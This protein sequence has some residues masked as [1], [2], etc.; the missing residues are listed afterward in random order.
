MPKILIL[1]AT[2]DIAEATAYVFAKAGFDLVLS[3]RNID[4][5]VPLKQD[6]EL[7]LKVDV[8]LLEL[9]AEDFDGHHKVLNNSYLHDIEVALLAFGYLGDQNKAQQDFKERMQLITVNYTAAVNCFE[10]IA[11]AFEKR[12]S[13]CIIG[14][15]SVAGERGRQ[16]NYVYGSAKGAFS[17][18]LS[19][20]RNRLHHSSVHVISVKPGFVDTKMTAALPLPKPLTAQPNDVAKAIYVAYKKQKNT[21]YSLWMWRYIMFIIRLVPEGIFKKLKM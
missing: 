1:G 15:S 12:K 20:L 8:S 19:G 16:S 3:G 4:R 9:D 18:Y 6:I 21:V 13:G 7:K 14:I 17:I 2:S 10:L 5:L 11:A